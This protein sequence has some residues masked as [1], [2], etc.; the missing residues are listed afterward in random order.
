VPVI[1]ILTDSGGRVHHYGFAGRTIFF[2][3]F[4]VHASAAQGASQHFIQLKLFYFLENHF[5]KVI[6]D[7]I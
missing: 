6:S 5:E 3:K 1:F 7:L 4:P 2:E